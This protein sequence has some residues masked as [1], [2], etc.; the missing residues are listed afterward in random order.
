MGEG[1]LVR[2]AD[3]YVTVLL[4]SDGTKMRYYDPAV[5]HLFADSSLGLDKTELAAQGLPRTEIT[6]PRSS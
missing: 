2:V 4:A 3:D 6:V 1:V 5:V